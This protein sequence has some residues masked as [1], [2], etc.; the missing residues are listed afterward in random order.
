MIMIFAVVF[1]FLLLLHL[2]LIGVGSLLINFGYSDITIHANFHKVWNI[3]KKQYVGSFWAVS[4]GLL[5]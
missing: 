3:Y 4:A 1:I 5:L 2:W